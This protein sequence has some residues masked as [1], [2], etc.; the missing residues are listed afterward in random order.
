MFFKEKRKINLGFYGAFDKDVT[1]DLI[2]SISF[3]LTF[4]FSSS[5]MK[6][7]KINSTVEF[8]YIIS[9]RNIEFERDCSLPRLSFSDR[10]G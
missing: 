6:I 8:F 4:L 7:I 3:S 9:E 1:L 10:I 5:K 2:A